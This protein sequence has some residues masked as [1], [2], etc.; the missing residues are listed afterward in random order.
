VRRHARWALEQFGTHPDA[1]A[2]LAAAPVVNDDAPTTTDA[3]P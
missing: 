2:A 3:A 1:R